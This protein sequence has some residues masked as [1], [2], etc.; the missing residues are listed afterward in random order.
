MDLYENFKKFEKKVTVDK[1][2]KKKNRW[3]RKN[4]V[5]SW[6]NKRDAGNNIKSAI[7]TEEYREGWDRI[8]GKEKSE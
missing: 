6:L 5:R 4:D 8:F 3:M 2:E 7:S 1:A